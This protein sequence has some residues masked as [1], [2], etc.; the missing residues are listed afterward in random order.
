M[1]SVEQRTKKVL[2]DYLAIDAA[3]LQDDNNL[4]LNLGLD[5]IDI[6][7]LGMELETEFDTEIPTEDIKA[8]MTVGE[9]VGAMRKLTS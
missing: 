1:E 2:A 4:V 5:S 8:S 7:Q 3:R 9:L 6:V